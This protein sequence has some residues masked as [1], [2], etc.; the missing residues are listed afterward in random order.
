MRKNSTYVCG[1]LSSSLGSVFGPLEL[2][3]CSPIDFGG[4]LAIKFF[5][6]QFGH[7]IILPPASSGSRIGVLQN[8][9]LTVNTAGLV[10]MTAGG[11]GIPF[12]FIP[13]SAASARHRSCKRDSASSRL[14]C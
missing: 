9:Q 14:A 10:G 1:C 12:V 8:E 7:A 2:V 11:V 5:A 6:L 3:E 13:A 4:C